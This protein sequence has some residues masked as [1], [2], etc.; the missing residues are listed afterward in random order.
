M[1]FRSANGNSN[2][3]AF[4]AFDAIEAAAEYA[5]LPAG[6]YTSRVVRGSK[7]TTKSGTPYYRI[8][9]EVLN[10]GEHKAKKVSRPFWFTPKAM[11]YSK[12][13]LAPF[14]LTTAASLSAPFPPPGREIVCR[15]TVT[16]QI[17]DDGQERNDIRKIEIVST[18]DSPALKFGVPPQ[19]AK[20]GPHQ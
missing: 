2:N 1:D 18:S 20:G 11:P 10:E 5:P 16:L 4:G 12:R 7:E 15:L 9:F 6:A 14:G 3:D 13:D 19:P 17:D 8:V